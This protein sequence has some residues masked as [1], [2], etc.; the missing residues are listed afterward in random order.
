MEGNN[1]ISPAYR[2]Q[3][4]CIVEFMS[5]VKYEF[6]CISVKNKC[7]I[8]DKADVIALARKV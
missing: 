5:I 4:H 7:F 8:S 3:N 6:I 2:W 1:F